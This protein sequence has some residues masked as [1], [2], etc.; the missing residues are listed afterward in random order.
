MKNKPI[1]PTAVFPK[2]EDM[3]YSLAW[4]FVHK[5]PQLEFEN[6]RSQAFESFMLACR[7]YD[8]GRGASFTTF[9]YSKV[10][11]GLQDMVMDN[12]RD[13]LVFVEDMGELEHAFNHESPAIPF[14]LSDLKVW[15]DLSHDAR[16]II[17]LLLE[18]PRE[19][20][21]VSWTKSKRGP[22]REHTHTP[23]QLLRRVKAHLV[24]VGRCKMRIKAA[25]QEITMKF[26]SVWNQN[27]ERVMV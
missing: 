7:K 20:M 4:R 13:R 12:S 10:W 14:H 22:R 8:P 27:T 1:N 9:C 5:Y 26:R 21:E 6:A 25:E 19:I 3:L 2:V 11:Y 17:S 15:E 23:K 16:E 18:S 24:Q